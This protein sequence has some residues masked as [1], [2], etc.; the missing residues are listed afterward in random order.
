MIKVLPYEIRL[1][2]YTLY[3]ELVKPI[4]PGQPVVFSLDFSTINTDSIINKFLP[5]IRSNLPDPSVPT[6]TFQP[7]I[8]AEVEFYERRHFSHSDTC[9]LLFAQDS[10]YVCTDKK[11]RS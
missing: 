8:F 6:F 11:C 7:S 3:L 2:I 9:Q 4:K 5:T 1:F 10:R